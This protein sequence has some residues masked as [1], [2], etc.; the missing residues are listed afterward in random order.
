MPEMTSNGPAD[1]AR[2][3]TGIQGPDD[4][5]HVFSPD[6]FAQRAATPERRMGAAA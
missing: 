5:P 6:V 3:A 1:A 2:A 4:S